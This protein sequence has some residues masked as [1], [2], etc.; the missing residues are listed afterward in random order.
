MPE[1]TENELPGDTPNSKVTKEEIENLSFEQLD[2]LADEGKLTEDMLQIKL[3][4]YQTAIQQE[5]ESKAVDTPENVEEHLTEFFRKSAP[6]AA[7]QIASLA[8]NAESESVRLSANKLIIQYAILEA[9]RDG[10]PIKD[11]LKNLRKQ[12]DPTPEELAS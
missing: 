3:Q 5:F 9:D 12:P 4:E 11:L 6:S 1:N 2:K 7:S 8:M 10:D